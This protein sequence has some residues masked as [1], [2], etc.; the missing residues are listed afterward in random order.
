VFYC[1]CTSKGYNL[2]TN[3]LTSH[4]SGLLLYLHWQQLQHLVLASLQPHQQL[5]VNKNTS[6]PAKDNNT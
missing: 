6:R 2:V 3:Y 4:I 5:T 1:R